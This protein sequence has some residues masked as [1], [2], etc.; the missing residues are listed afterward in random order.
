MT[1]DAITTSHASLQTSAFECTDCA[2]CRECH[3]CK[4]CTECHE[5]ADRQNKI[6]TGIA[7]GVVQKILESIPENTEVILT[8]TSRISAVP[9]DPRY[10]KIWNN[11]KTQ[12]KTIWFVE[13]IRLDQDIEYFASLPHDIRESIKIVLGFFAGSDE[14]V[15]ENIR[16]YFLNDITI[17][18]I[19]YAYSVQAFMENVHSEMYNTLIVRL[20]GNDER[21]SILRAVE[22][23]AAVQRKADWARR[24]SASSSPYSLRCIAFACVEGIFF[25]S[26]FAF[27]DWL[28]TRNYK[29]QGLYESNLYISN[30]EARHQELA[31][32]VYQQIQDRQP[33]SV[34]RELIDEAVS[35]ELTFVD[36]VL[37]TGYT[38]MNAALMGRHVRHCAAI[39]ATMLGYP[40]MYTNTECPFEFMLKR[41]LDTKDNFFEEESVQ[42]T[43]P[44]VGDANANVF[45]CDTAF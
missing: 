24:W 5:I 25:S 40:G 27:I 32:L 26:S 10:S 42:Y 16:L 4:D 12:K 35:I 31:C 3:E 14:I 11:Y 19:K 41:S 15:S 7:S 29:L 8:P 21:T 28:K 39:L 6:I 36:E 23:Y 38:G 9:L 43:L 13:K 22:T 45:S 44:D 33:E 17:P 34:V 37:P 30:D 20:V 1:T 18:E 2:E